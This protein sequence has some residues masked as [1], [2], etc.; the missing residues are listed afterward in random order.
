MSADFACS[1]EILLAANRNLDQNAWNFLMGAT[2][3]ETTMRRNRLGLDSLAFRPRVLIDVSEVDPSTRILGHPLRIPVMLAPIGGLELMDREGAVAASRAAAAFGTSNCV[4]SLAKPELEVTAAITAAPKIFQPY[5][6][7]DR[8]WI[9]ELVGR[10][11]KAGYA[12]LCHTVDSAYY[13]NRER[14][15]MSRW[16]PPSKRGET[17][18]FWQSKSTW[19]TM[20]FIRDIWGGSFVLKGI[21]TAQDAAIAVEH[22]VDVVYVSNHGGRELDHGQATID[23]LPEIVKAVSGKAEIIVDSG[24]MRGSDA[25]KAIALGANAVAIG[26]LQ[27]LALAAGGTAGLIRAL[28]ILET[29]VITTMGLIGV[30]RLD[31]L[32]PAHVCKARPV[33]PPHEMSTFVHLPGGR[34]I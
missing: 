16:L 33:T 1:Q 22:G 12:A 31:Q 7:G 34:I 5:I 32:N 17:Q 20:D 8:D 14:Q 6:R 3:S 19:E 21:A 24:F 4:S 28:E 2:E 10:A 26:R 23:M 15:L 9:A 13:G 30:S 18:R 25:V 11:K 27:G 29:E